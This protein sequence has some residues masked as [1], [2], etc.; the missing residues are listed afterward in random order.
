DDVEGDVLRHHGM[1]RRWRYL[2]HHFLPF[3]GSVARLFPATGHSNVVAGYERGRLVARDVQLPGDQYVET[4]GIGGVDEE[5]MGHGGKKEAGN[6]KQ[7]TGTA[8]A[9]KS[10]PQ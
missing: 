8:H 6:R 10:S 7:E 1:L 2:Y 9:S 5:G 4:S 3:H